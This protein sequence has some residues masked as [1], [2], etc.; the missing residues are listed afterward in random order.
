[1]IQ[2]NNFPQIY[3]FRV[4]LRELSPHIWR[5]ILIGSDSTIVDLHRA[6]QIAFNWTDRYSRRFKIRGRILTLTESTAE[7]DDPATVPRLSEFHFFLKERFWYDYHFEHPLRRVWHHEL[8]L[9]KKLPPEAK[10]VYP[11]CISAVGAAPPEDCGGPKAF[12]EFRE[13][14]TARFITRRIA[15]MLDEGLSEQPLDE[16]RHLRPWMTLDGTD[17]RSINRRLKQDANSENGQGGLPS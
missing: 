8:R 17:R 3:Q 14:F 13:L 1:M 2:A 16:L 11:R 15:E 10:T 4:V 7:K 6:I 9:E 12:V 5:R